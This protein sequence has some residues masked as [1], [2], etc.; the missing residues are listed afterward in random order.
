[1]EFKD[2]NVLREPMGIALDKQRNVYVAGKELM[3][4]VERKEMLNHSH[5]IPGARYGQC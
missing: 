5:C 3:F 4:N 2:E 1:M